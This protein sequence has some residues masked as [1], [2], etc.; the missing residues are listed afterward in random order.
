[1]QVGASLFFAYASRPTWSLP[2][3]DFVLLRPSVLR[4][5]QIHPP[6]VWLC[7]VLV[8]KS[9]GLVV[10]FST[11]EELLYVMQGFI[12]RTAGWLPFPSSTSWIGVQLMQFLLLSEKLQLLTDYC[13]WANHTWRSFH[14][15]HAAALTYITEKVLL[16]IFPRDHLCSESALDKL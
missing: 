4:Q 6:W 9:D 10:C 5:W 15:D 3:S 7:L 13:I 11:E 14:L 16:V 1:M 12:L 2:N 8:R